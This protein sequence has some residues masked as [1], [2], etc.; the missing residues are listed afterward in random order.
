MAQTKATTAPVS[1]TEDPIEEVHQEEIVQ[2]IGYQNTIKKLIAGGARLI[3]GVRIKNVNVVEKDNYKRVSFT[4]NTLVPGYTQNETTLEWEKAKVATIYSSTYAIAGAIKEDEDKAWLGR[5]IDER[6]QSL[7]LILNG[8][9]VDIIQQEFEAGEEIINPFTTK[10]NP[11][12]SVTDHA[13][14]I[15]HVIKFNFGST[16]AR[17]ADRLADKLLGF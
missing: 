2:G 9:T 16:G 11:E 1:K 14:I 13:T 17:M 3:K 5:E 4:L 12:G 15:N 8:G 6:P 10:A 7:N